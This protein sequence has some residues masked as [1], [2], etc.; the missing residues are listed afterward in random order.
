MTFTIQFKKGVAEKAVREII[1]WSRLELPEIT[2]EINFTYSVAEGNFAFS[3]KALFTIHQNNFAQNFVNFSVKV[4]LSMVNGKWK[5]SN[6]CERKVIVWI[7]NSQ[8]SYLE[9]KAFVF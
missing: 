6:I 1:A 4:C 9:P 7:N 8:S 2:S 5:V 3:L